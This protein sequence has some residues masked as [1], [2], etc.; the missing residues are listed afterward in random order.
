VSP[1]PAGKDV[2][3]NDGVLPNNGNVIPGV[4]PITSTTTTNNADATRTTGQSRQSE[5]L[6]YVVKNLRRPVELSTITDV[7]PAIT[8][9]T[10][11]NG[12][13]N[14]PQNYRYI[15]SASRRSFT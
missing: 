7:A 1:W 8:P 15:N 9:G 5:S 4:M 2:V 13:N 6:N 3:L 10:T 11:T 14:N 12:R